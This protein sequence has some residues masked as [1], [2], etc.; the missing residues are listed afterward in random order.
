[1]V[2]TFWFDVGS[3]N[4]YL[5]HRVLP[6]IEQRTGAHF[7]YEPMLLGGLFKLSGNQSPMVAFANIPKK[8]DYEMLEIRRFVAR[9]GLT[10]FQMNPHFPINTLPLMRMATAAKMDGTLAPTV[11]VLF[12]HMWERGTNMGDPSTVRSA[13]AD[14][15]LDVDRLVAR[16]QEQDVKDALVANTQRAFERGAFGAPTVFVD[17]EMFFGKDRLRDVEDEITRSR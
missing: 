4:A 10:A 11:E 9:H 3:P 12:Q 16:A 17:D 2:T 13:L 6:G 14:G 8:L 1:M 5:A 7:V 15:G